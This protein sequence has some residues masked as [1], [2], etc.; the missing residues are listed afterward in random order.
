M[1][2]ALAVRQLT[3]PAQPTAVTTTET[4]KPSRRCLQ[5]RNDMNS[6]SKS[7][8]CNNNNCNVI[9]GNNFNCNNTNR[10]NC[11][12]NNSS[13]IVWTIADLS[14]TRNKQQQ[15]QQQQLQQQQQQ[16]RNHRALVFNAQSGKTIS[17]GSGFRFHFY[18]GFS[19]SKQ[20]L[21]FQAFPASEWL[22]FYRST[23]KEKKPGCDFCSK[24]V[25]L[26]SDEEHLRSSLWSQSRSFQQPSEEIDSWLLCS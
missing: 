19:V 5:V 18:F 13:S 9:N 4:T 12:N 14:S 7:S 10:N 21:P 3:H 22:R 17:P 26:N 2:V 20:F 16:H 11:Y 1:S 25:S 8:K 23:K 6:N 24:P 15:Q